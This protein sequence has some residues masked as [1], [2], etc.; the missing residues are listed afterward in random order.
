MIIEINRDFSKII[1]IYYLINYLKIFG[2]RLIY[3][4]KNK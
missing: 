3:N 2:N 4:F 1:K